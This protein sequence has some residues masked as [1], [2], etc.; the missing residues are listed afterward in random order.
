MQLSRER[1]VQHVLLL[2]LTGHESFPTA[3]FRGLAYVLRQL[4]ESFRFQGGRLCNTGVSSA[5]TKLLRDRMGSM[6]SIMCRHCGG[7]QTRPANTDTGVL[8]ANAFG[9]EKLSLPERFVKA[10]V[11]LLSDNKDPQGLIDAVN[12]PLLNAAD[13]N[14]SV[15]YLLREMF[16]LGLFE[17]PYT[18][19]EKAQAVANSPASAAR[20][21]EAHRNRS[22]CCATTGSCCPSRRQE[23]VRRVRQEGAALE[24]ARHRPLR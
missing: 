9:V 11:N 2:A 5:L 3:C 1:F 12:Q 14:P 20:A 4:S 21:N 18:D 17:N 24:I 22:S 7:P 23:R 13:L 8:G 16:Q 10:G 6:G 15:T 19:P